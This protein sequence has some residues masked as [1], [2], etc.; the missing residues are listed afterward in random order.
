MEFLHR[1]KERIF[2]NIPSAVNDFK[3]CICHNIFCHLKMA[4]VRAQNNLTILTRVPSSFVI[5]NLGW[6]SKD[7]HKKRSTQSPTTQKST[8]NACMSAF[9]PDQQTN[10]TT[11]DRKPHILLIIADDGIGSLWE[12]MMTMKR[13]CCWNWLAWHPM[14]QDFSHPLSVWLTDTRLLWQRD[15]QTDEFQP[16][17][18]LL[19]PGSTQG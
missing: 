9:Q 15:Q 6:H 2:F 19:S 8:S 5:E 13:K 3:R 4:M 16:K 7:Q 1:N 17:R 10:N 11:I 12:N 18:V 14:R